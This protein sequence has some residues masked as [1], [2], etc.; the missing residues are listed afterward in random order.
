[1]DISFAPRQHNK[2]QDPRLSVPLI[3]THYLSRIS[4]CIDC[5]PRGPRLAVQYANKYRVLQP[6]TD[7]DIHEVCPARGSDLQVNLYANESI[8]TM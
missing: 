8:F 7:A 5:S 6:V 1:M 4:L 3:P 2:Q